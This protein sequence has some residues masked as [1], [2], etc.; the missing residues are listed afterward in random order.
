MASL[1]IE[2]ILRGTT[3]A[4]RRKT[5]KSI[6]NGAGL[7][8]VYDATLERIKAQD[9]EKAELAM[10]TLTWIC[11]SER[12]L[13]V[14]ELSHALAVEI[15]EADFDPENAPSIGTLLDCCQGLITVDAEASTIRLIHYAVQEYLCSH[16][17]LF[18]KPHSVLAETCLTYL[19]SQ[20]VK[21]LTPHSLP[22]PQ[23]MPFLKYS[24]RY[25]GTHAN[26]D[27]SD[28]VRMLALELLNQ[29]GDHIS[30]VS[31]LGQMTRPG[32]IEGI[33]TPP[34]FFA[35]H[36]ASFFGIVE[37]VTVLIN[38]E[39]CKVDQQECIGSAPLA[40]AARNGHEGVVKSLLEREG[41]D[42]K[43]PD[44][45]DRTPLGCAALNGHEEVVKLLLERKD[46]APN[47][48]DISDR[49]PLG[50]AAIEGHAGVVKL[51]LERDN[52]T[53]IAQM[54]MVGDRSGV[55]LSRD[56]QAWSSYC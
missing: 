52:S 40:W 35:L 11:H 37:L 51:L 17:G 4:R 9:E 15:G 31:L 24:A 33:A 28:N 44:K 8:E 53:P 42:P 47:H 30:A 38:S 48:P 16:P 7:G 29:Y 32:F 1:H 25:W 49:T 18:S 22:A 27:F 36:Y 10:A 39:R 3:I 2:A 34:L 12:P 43:P 45:N 26:W 55:L 56:T 23:N 46:V 5:L 19:N 20:Q 21:N 54:W 6:S 13:L 14:D 50:C 41:V